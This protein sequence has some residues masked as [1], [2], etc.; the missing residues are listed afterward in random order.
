MNGSIA[1][2]WDEHL[3]CE[4]ETHD[5]EGAMNTMVKEPYV[6]DVPTGGIGHD[7]VYDFYKNHF[8]GKTP[9]DTN[10]VHISRTVSNDQVVDEFIF[11][12][13]HDTELE[14]MLPEITPTDKHV[15]VH[16]VAIIKFDGD[17]IAHEHIYSDQASVLAQIG[18]IGTIGLP[19]MGQ[20]GKQ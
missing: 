16:L 1:D 15:E 18:L 2:V 14:F 9:A 11:S 8:I 10:I 5:V 13:T 7:G 3:K 12:F 17:K 4:F 19:I 6:H 20:T